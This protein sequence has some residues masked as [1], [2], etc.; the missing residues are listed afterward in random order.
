[1]T[2]KKKKIIELKKK[3]LTEAELQK[4]AE[5]DA[6]KLDALWELAINGNARKLDALKPAL[7]HIKAE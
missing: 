3:K 7:S 1:M 4:S 2:K 5:T 6:A